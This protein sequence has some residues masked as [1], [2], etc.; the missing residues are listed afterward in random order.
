MRG[1]QA[2][3]PSLYALADE[4]RAVRTPVLILAG[5]EDEGS[6][7]PSLMLKRTIP[8]SGLSVLPR[9]GHTLNLEEPE[10]FNAE[11]ERFIDSAGAGSWTSRDPRAVPGSIT[12]I[13]T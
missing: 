8:T 13:R 7:E 5:D 6:L 4:F 9:T 1:V 10:L 11:V 2:T 3:R 12:G